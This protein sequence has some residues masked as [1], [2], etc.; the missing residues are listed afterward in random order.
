MRY[1]SRL[2]NFQESSH[3]VKTLFSNFCRNPLETIDH[4][5][6]QL[7]EKFTSYLAWMVGK[8]E[9]RH[10]EFFIDNHNN[11]NKNGIHWNDAILS[12]N[13]HVSKTPILERGVIS[14]IY[15]DR[16]SKLSDKVDPMFYGCKFNSESEICKFKSTTISICSGFG[17]ILTSL[18]SR[19]LSGKEST[20]NKGRKQ[21]IYSLF[22]DSRITADM[23]KSA[24]SGSDL[25]VN[26]FDN[27]YEQ[28]VIFQSLFARN[29]PLDTARYDISSSDTRILD[30]L[31]TLFND[32]IHVVTLTRTGA[33]S[34]EIVLGLYRL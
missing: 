31:F 28:L 21:S 8:M 25:M 2:C 6:F 9:G 1:K 3:A 15:G 26:W 19:H 16:L 14:R 13:T 33:L 27:R 10:E 32:I 18:D 20:A 12:A 7:I 22:S 23:V 29:L 24:I 11:S 4:E 30:E 17:S 5:R 34:Y